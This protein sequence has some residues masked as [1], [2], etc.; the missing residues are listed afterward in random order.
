MKAVR[1]PLDDWRADPAKM[2][3]A[4]NRNTI[5]LVG[6]FPCWPY[7]R[8]DPIEAL[9]EV[10]Q[11]H[12]LWLHVDACVGGYFAPFCAEAGYKTPPFDFSVPGVTSISA[13]L[14]KYGYCPPPCSTVLWRS[15]ELEPYRYSGVTADE[16]P[17]GAYR[18]SGFT[19]SRPAS[20]VFAAWALL[21]HLG[22]DGYVE[23]T[24]RTLAAKQRVLEGLEQLPGIQPHATDAGLVVFSSNIVP[25]ETLSAGLFDRNWFVFGVR[26]PKLLQLIIGPCSDEA[27]EPFLSDLGAIIRSSRNSQG[28]KAGRLDY[29]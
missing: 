4:V 20:S 15:D 21:R 26:D 18:T 11:R 13:D 17:S 3:A 8:F 16:W 25:L 19:G 22:R 9:S 7:G 10:A 28:T 5:A 1:V 6:S 12:H 24:R 2:E 29:T 27:I 23:L 14:H